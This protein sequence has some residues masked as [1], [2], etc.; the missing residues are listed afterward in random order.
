MIEDLVKSIIAYT[1][2]PS[3]C[4][5]ENSSN[6]TFRVFWYMPINGRKHKSSKNILIAISREYFDDN[7]LN[8][9]P[10]KKF[11]TDFKSFLQHNISNFEKESNHKPGE[12]PPEEKWVFCG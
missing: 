11:I 6:I 7:L 5:K 8:R 3:V 1:L 12:L 10:P 9:E 4:E 2:K